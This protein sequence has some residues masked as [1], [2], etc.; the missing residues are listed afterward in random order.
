MTE[1]KKEHP[2]YHKTKTVYRI[3]CVVAEC[4]TICGKDISVRNNHSAYET[5]ARLKDRKSCEIELH[6][7]NCWEVVGTKFHSVRR[8]KLEN[9]NY[10]EQCVYCD[11][12][13]GDVYHQHTYK[14]QKCGEK[15]P[16][17]YCGKIGKS[18]VTRHNFEN[19][20]L[21]VFDKCTECGKMR[22]ETSKMD[23]GAR[24]AEVLSVFLIAFAFQY[25]VRKRKFIHFKWLIVM[26]MWLEENTHFGNFC[27]AVL[28]KKKLN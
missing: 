1:Y 28:W 27:P 12:I 4:C 15:G 3:K 11:Y 21:R 16:C 17:I 19:P 5:V 23:W 6:C 18:S 22:Y 9:G 14:T 13:E 7:K 26:F 20:F 24:V 8:V 2:D 10:I 25:V